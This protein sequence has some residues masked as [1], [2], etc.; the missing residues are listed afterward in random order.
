VF[1]NQENQNGAKKGKLI[2]FSI[3]KAGCSPGTLKSLLEV[4][5]KYITVFL[6]I[7]YESIY[8]DPD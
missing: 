6:N 5:D 8:L 4:F 1:R 7:D 2:L 3:P